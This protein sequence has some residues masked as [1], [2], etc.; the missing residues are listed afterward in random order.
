MIIKLYENK[1]N[2]SALYRIYEL[3]RDGVYLGDVGY[4]EA[5]QV[6]PEKR[7]YRVSQL[8]K[9]MNPII[10]KFASSEGL[11]FDEEKILAWFN[12]NGEL[13]NKSLKKIKRKIKKLLR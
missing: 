12:E 8:S 6:S 9:L 1:Q 4:F 2:G 3:V 7:E 11:A 5:K 13:D 10:E